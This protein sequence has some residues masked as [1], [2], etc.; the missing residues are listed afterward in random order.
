MASYKPTKGM[1][2]EAKRGLEWR[3]EYNRGGTQVGVSRARDIVNGRNLSSQTVRRMKSFFARHEVDKQGEGFSPGEEGFPSAGRIAWALWGGDPGQS[4]S[5][6]IVRREENQNMDV[7][8]SALRIS[9]EETASLELVEGSETD[10]RTKFRM[11]AN[12]GGVIEGHPHWGNFSIDLE[13]L[14][15]GRQRKPALRDHDAQRIVGHTYSI[16]VTDEGLVA[17]GTFSD[18]P[19][20][21]EVSQMLSDGFPWQAS[22]YVPPKAIERLEEGQTAKVNGRT[23]TGPG[24][25]FRESSLREVTFTS[26]GADENTHAHALSDTVKINAVFTAQTEE[27]S[28]D[29]E[30]LQVEETVPV[31]DQTESTTDDAVVL[32]DTKTYE[33]GLEAGMQIM[34]ERVATF[35]DHMSKDQIDLVKDLVVKQVSEQDGLGAMLKNVNSAS[36][37]RLREKM[38]QAN[39]PVGPVDQEE[40]QDPQQKFEQSPDLVAQFGSFEIYEAYNRALAQGAIKNERS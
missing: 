7:P 32:S 29:Q 38:E 33:Q 6:A 36:A 21:R 1:I 2:E 16:Q 39:D 11:V 18:T 15:I 28:M 37:E 30:E 17:E 4:W 13:G 27:V 22:V 10:T 23:I 12:S 26:L 35:M 31:S 24:H 25:I 3:A 20:G 8:K 14:N 40:S 9:P 5:E 19:D 34:S